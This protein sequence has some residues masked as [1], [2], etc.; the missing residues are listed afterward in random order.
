MPFHFDEYEER[1][2]SLTPE[3]LQRE[4]EKY[5]RLI[6]SASTSTALNGVALPFT[7]GISIIGIGLAAPYIH[8]ARKKREIIERQL[9]KH[10][11]THHTR[12]RDVLVSMAA[13]GTITGTTLLVGGVGADAITIAGVEHGVSA[14]IENEIATKAVT[15]AAL[16]GVGLSVEH[17]HEDHSRK[18]NAG[19]S[20]GFSGGRNNYCS[21]HF[22]SPGHAIV[23]RPPLTPKTQVSSVEN[24]G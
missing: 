24:V 5:T 23:L 4:W 10:G 3:E 16:D 18:K 11:S 17:A 19:A 1:C 8:N 14:I 22:Q 2:N 15:H 20:G 9:Q 6:S 21:A 7:L 13:S 12:M